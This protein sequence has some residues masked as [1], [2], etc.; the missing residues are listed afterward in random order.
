MPLQLSWKPAELIH[1]NVSPRWESPPIRRGS[2]EQR[3]WKYQQRMDR[4]YRLRERYEADKGRPMMMHES[5]WIGGLYMDTLEHIE[6][7]GYEFEEDEFGEPTWK[8][9]A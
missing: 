2:R 3:F 6:A 9:R 5:L 4:F 1:I 7:L 8:K